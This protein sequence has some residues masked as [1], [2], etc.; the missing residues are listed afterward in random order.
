MTKERENFVCQSCNKPFSMS[1]EK[2]EIIRGASIYLKNYLT[3]CSTCREK[4]DKK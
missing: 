3:Y 4:G 1:K 2:A